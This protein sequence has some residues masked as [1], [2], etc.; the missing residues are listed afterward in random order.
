MKK[1]E[2][3][4]L[5]REVVSEVLREELEP[6]KEAM[7]IQLRESLQKPS[8]KMISKKKR[9]PRETNNSLRKAIDFSESNIKV[10]LT[11]NPAI[12]DILNETRDE[13][14]QGRSSLISEADRQVRGISFGSQDAMGFGMQRKVES[15]QIPLTSQLTFNPESPDDHKLQQKLHR[16]QQSGDQETLDRIKKTEEMIN[17]DYSSILKASIEKSKAKQPLR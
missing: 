16:A 13:I 2:L 15:G 9:T 12:D 8:G 4:S 3:K 14:A 11:G 17:R 10:P 5:I 7:A 6:L 1:Q